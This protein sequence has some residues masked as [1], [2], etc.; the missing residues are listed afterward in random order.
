MKLLFALAIVLVCKFVQPTPLWVYKDDK[1][2]Q[3]PIPDT[4]AKEN[5]QEDPKPACRPCNQQLH[6]P[7]SWKC[8]NACH[9]KTGY[10]SACDV[11]G[12][13]G[14]AC[15]RR[16]F[17]G[18]GCDPATANK[19]HHSCQFNVKA[20]RRPNSWNCWNACHKKTGYCAACGP[21]GAC[22]RKGFT[23]GWS[24]AGCNSK[25]ANKKHHS[26]QYNAKSDEGMKDPIAKSE[27]DEKNVQEDPF[28][29]FYR[30]P[31]C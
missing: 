23:A 24:N 8:W 1:S 16:G 19:K 12:R 2:E 4:D 21:G 28:S 18:F 20:G 6:N 14:G 15:C 25:T 30:L 17:K 11:N 31:C 13:K 10:C 29:A 5:V 27:K 22:C 9:K 3:E 7:T 26:C